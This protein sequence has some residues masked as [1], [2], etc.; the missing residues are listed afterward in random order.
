MIESAYYIAKN[1]ITLHAF[2]VELCLSPTRF[3]QEDFN[4][5]YLPRVT[6]GAAPTRKGRVYKNAIRTLQKCYTNAFQLAIIRDHNL[7]CS[8]TFLLLGKRISAGHI[9][10]PTYCLPICLGSVHY[11]KFKLN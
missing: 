11:K 8:T 9:L 3:P 5:S 7:F 2:R 4:Y 1:A 6:A 10:N